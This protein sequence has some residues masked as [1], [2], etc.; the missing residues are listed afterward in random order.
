MCSASFDAFSFSSAQIAFQCLA[1]VLVKEDRVYWTD[2]DTCSASSARFK[3][4]CWIVKFLVDFYGAYWTGRDARHSLT[5]LG[6]T[7]DRLI[8]SVE[9]IAKNPDPRFSVIDFSFVT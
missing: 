4:K 5:F 3:I 6:V 7:N 2:V 9:G 1:F 8:Y